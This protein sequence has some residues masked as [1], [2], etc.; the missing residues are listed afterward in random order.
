MKPLRDLLDEISLPDSNGGKD[1]RGTVLIIGGP[2]SCPGAVMLAGSASLRVGSG[3]VQLTVHPD[4]AAATATAVPETKV[5]AWD[6]QS[7]PPPGVREQIGRADVVVVGPGHG[8]LDVDVVA[9]IAAECKDECRLVL[10]AGALG[11]A[12]RLV[13]AGTAVVAAPNHAEACDL[14][15]RSGEVEELAAP[16]AQ[17]LQAPTAVRGATTVVAHDGECWLFED[18]PSGLGTPGSGDVFV[19]T[20]AGLL[21]CGG[22]PLG[23]LA[24]AVTLHAAAGAR[25]ARTTPVGYTASDVVRELPY[26]RAE[27]ERA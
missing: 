13:R 2:P 22:D 24:W 6:Q 10:D 9:A 7:S 17:S 1:A 5:V 11:A 12:M 25:L 21:A 19:G 15:G 8:K 23:A 3:R 18:S 20:L 26:A 16:L 27:F 4:V 14:V